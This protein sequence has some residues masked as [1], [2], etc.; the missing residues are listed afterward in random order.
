MDS[1]AP[2]ALALAFATE[3]TRSLEEIAP[4]FSGA[5]TAQDNKLLE[6]RIYQRRQFSQQL[7]ELAPT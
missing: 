5:T 6:L 3:V 7:N 1:S 4:T 2:L